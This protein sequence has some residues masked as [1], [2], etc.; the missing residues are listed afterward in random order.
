MVIGEQPNL[1]TSNILIGGDATHVIPMEEV[2]LPIARHADLTIKVLP[3]DASAFETLYL[4]PPICV[5]GTQEQ[6]IRDV[7]T[8]IHPV[9]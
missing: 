8:V 1:V 6:A 9:E 2:E 4:M 7:R 3:S 5:L